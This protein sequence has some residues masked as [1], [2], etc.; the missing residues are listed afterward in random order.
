MKNENLEFQ[1]IIKDRKRLPL[2]Q[3]NKIKNNIFFNYI[4]FLIMI[5]ITLIINLS[6]NKLSIN[7]FNKYIDII[8]MFCGIFSIIILEIAYKNDS[9]KIGIYGIEF[10]LYSICVLFVP[11]FYISKNNVNFLKIIWIFNFFSVYL[12]YGK[13]L[14]QS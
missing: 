14:L 6:F 3:K 5:F 11:H 12:H 7:D 1:D 8:Q 4:L 13:E 2:E 9:E 10:L